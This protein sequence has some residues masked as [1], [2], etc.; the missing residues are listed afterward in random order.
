M[1][2]KAGLIFESQL[3]VVLKPVYSGYDSKSLPRYLFN[4]FKYF[5]NTGFHARYTIRKRRRQRRQLEP[6][7]TYSFSKFAERT[8]MTSMV[9]CRKL[10]NCRITPYFTKKNLNKKKLRTFCPTFSDSSNGIKLNPF[11]S[12]SFEH[13]PNVHGHGHNDPET[14]QT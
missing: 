1:E 4:T 7:L 14:Y 12:R 5:L 2:R 10:Q 13:D 3:N 8:T 6:N 11:L 9:D